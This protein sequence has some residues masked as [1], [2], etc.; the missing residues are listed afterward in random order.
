MIANFFP[1]FCKREKRR[2]RYENEFSRP[3]FAKL[4]C[5]GFIFYQRQFVKWKWH[6]LW[7]LGS[8]KILV[9]KDQSWLWLFF[10]V[11]HQGAE[12]RERR[13]RRKGGKTGEGGVDTFK[14]WEYYL[15]FFRRSTQGKTGEK[16]NWHIDGLKIG[17]FFQE[18]DPSAALA[19]EIRRGPRG[20][21]TL[22]P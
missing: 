21:L 14:H 17:F 13:L 18:L 8:L 11:D 5:P 20:R 2:W 19:E 9:L 6:L 1:F 22:S 7:T 15:L 12:E 3:P 10:Q 16:I 4:S